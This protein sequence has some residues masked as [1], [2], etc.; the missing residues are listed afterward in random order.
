MRIP[1]NERTRAKSCKHEKVLEYAHFHAR[2]RCQ[3]LDFFNSRMEH[4]RMRGGTPHSIFRSCTHCGGSGAEALLRSVH[5]NFIH[6]PN[7]PS[8]CGREPNRAIAI[9]THQHCF[10]GPDARQAFQDGAQ[11]RVRH[12]KLSVLHFAL[13]MYRPIACSARSAHATAPNARRGFANNRNLHIP[14]SARL[15]KCARAEGARAPNS[16]R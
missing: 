11:Y 15:A 5:Q 6:E 3:Y 13:I 7:A 9:P 2:S 8:P 12:G 14:H 16:A 10:C 1:P 4:L